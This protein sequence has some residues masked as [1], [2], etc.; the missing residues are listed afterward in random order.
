MKDNKSVKAGDILVCISNEG[1]SSIGTRVL[2]MGLT[3]KSINTCGSNTGWSSRDSFR[4]GNYTHQPCDVIPDE[5]LQ[6]REVCE[7]VWSN[8]ILIRKQVAK[9]LNK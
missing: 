1:Y 9:R 3:D 5:V 6:F 8:N 4:W 2:I 7:K